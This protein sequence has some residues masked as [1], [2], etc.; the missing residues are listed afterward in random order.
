MF[1]FEIRCKLFGGRSV[2]PDMEKQ[3]EP[4]SSS[5]L[6]LKVRYL[7]K[8]EKELS[9]AANG[10]HSTWKPDTVHDDNASKLQ[11]HDK[12]PHETPKGKN[13]KPHSESSKC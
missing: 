1:P 5:N 8:H 10:T 9:A 11:M 2:I 6:L 12:K 4:F 3:C 13:A 7:H